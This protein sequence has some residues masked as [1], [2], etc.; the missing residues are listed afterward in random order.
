M[1]LHPPSNHTKTWRCHIGWHAYE[2]VRVLEQKSYAT[3][4]LEGE[5]CKRCQH[6]KDQQSVWEV[7]V[8]M[9]MHN[10]DIPI[11]KHPAVKL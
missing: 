11:T 2:T 10:K 8:L 5:V 6:L 3:L 7:L 9:R 1:S 4:Y